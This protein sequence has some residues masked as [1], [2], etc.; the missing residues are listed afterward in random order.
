MYI[1]E[2]RK[3]GIM[4]LALP[5]NN[6]SFT[7]MKQLI[8]TATNHYPISST[9]RCSFESS[10]VSENS[11]F[12]LFLNLGLVFRGVNLI[13]HRKGYNGSSSLCIMFGLEM[14]KKYKIGSRATP[15][16]FMQCSQSGLRSLWKSEIQDDG[17]LRRRLVFSGIRVKWHDVK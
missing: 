16:E 14:K 1:K 8:I 4:Q 7:A 12:L 5:D 13:H 9:M 6:V 11:L 17:E 10:K 3:H 15:V 2:W